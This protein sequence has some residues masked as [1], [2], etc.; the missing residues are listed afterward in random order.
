MVTSVEHAKREEPAAGPRD[1]GKT[2]ATILIPPALRHQA[3]TLA[4]SAGG[5]AIP[6]INPQDFIAANR[7]HIKDASLFIDPYLVIHPR[8]LAPENEA[9]L[10]AK[11]QLTYSL[12][13]PSFF[14][15]HERRAIAFNLGELVPV[16][17]TA[18]HSKLLEEI[19]QFNTQI[20]SGRDAELQRELDDKHAPFAAIV[21]DV[22]Q[23]PEADP[24]GLETLKNSLAMY[25]LVREKLTQQ[26]YLGKL[27]DY[28]Q[29]ITTPD[30]VLA[31][32][33]E[34]TG[35]GPLAMREAALKDGIDGVGRLLGLS[36]RYVADVKALTTYAATQDFS[37]NLVEHWHLGRQLQGLDAPLAEKII[38]GM[39][40][41]ITAKIDEYRTRVHRLYD[42]PEPTKKEQ[43]RIAEA[44]SFVEP[45]QRALLFKQ[46]YEICYSPEVTADD[47]AFHPGIYGL[48][49]KTANDLRDAQGTYRIYFAGRGDL[50]SSIRTLVHEIAH[51]LWPEQFAPGE[52]AKIDQLAAADQQRFT[53]FQAMMD[54]HY[55]AFEKLFRAYQAGNAQEKQAVIASA[56]RMFAAYDFHAAGLF[57]YLRD[58]HDFQF[59]VRHAYDTL[60]IEGARYTHSGYNSP[61]ERFREVISRFAELTQVEYR[62][63][64][65]FLQFLAPGLNQIWEAHY[66]PHLARVAQA[67][68]NGTIKPVYDADKP[69]ADDVLVVA[70]GG[71]PVPPITP[72]TPPE[73]P[74]LVDGAPLTSVNAET[75]SQKT[76]CAM[77]T[78]K[79]MGVYV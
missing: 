19:K 18:K 7:I 20:D 38:V 6:G 15:S 50:K 30:Q 72:P 39:D 73:H 3:A 51:N 9:A 65:Q 61:E 25:L 45:T 74:C 70:Q 10:R 17:T 27:T 78:L 28:V 68:D 34:K 46:G 67:L 2:V 14:E 59:A 54:D 42:V 62:G 40:A 44:L 37:Y 41:R 64:P 5:S 22:T 47:I 35:V 29:R 23:H 4:H 12:N 56:D 77:N 71:E 1:P 66:L 32:L 11:L 60:S 69:H 63:E 43:Q 21:R 55:P 33:A 16:S 24:V 13:N 8:E 52:V 76:F 36:D 57:P 26:G 49:R 31:D 48:H 79:A 75:I 58:A 53:R